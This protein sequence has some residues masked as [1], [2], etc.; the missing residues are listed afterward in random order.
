MNATRTKRTEKLSPMKAMGLVEASK[1]L[2]GIRFEQ[3]RELTLR[4]QASWDQARRGPGRPRKAPAEKAARV[5]VTIAPDLLARADDYA[6]RHRISRAEL[7][8]RGIVTIL[9]K[10]AGSPKTG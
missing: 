7:F 6:H 10:D 1:K 5:L 3:T 9:A 4:E 8:A 2:G